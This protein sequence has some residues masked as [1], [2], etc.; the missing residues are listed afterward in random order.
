[1]HIKARN[2]N[3]AFSTALL[4]LID[5]HEE[6]NSRVGPIIAFPGPVMIEYGRPTERV[7]FSAKRNANPVF[8]LLESLWM[9][10]G[11][12]DVK[13]P[14]TIVKRMKTFS[15]DG[16]TLWGAY[17][18]RWR[19]FFGYDQIEWIISELIANPESRRCVLAMWNAMDNTQKARAAFEED[20][21]FSSD[22]YV[23]THGGKDVPCNTHIYFDCR[24]GRLNMTVCNRSND[25]VWGC[26][27]A[28][29]VHMSVL[30]E[31]MALAIGIPV[32]VY[33]QFTNDLHLYTS[34]Y[35]LDTLGPMAYDADCFDQ[36]TKGARPLPLWSGD[37]TKE[38]FDRDVADF[39]NGFDTSG[40]EILCIV[41]VEYRT[42]FFNHTVMPMVRA[43]R[44]RGN[45]D[46]AP[47]L[48]EKIA[49]PDW[50]IATRNWLL[51]NQ[52]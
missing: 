16:K 38:D 4:G 26:F 20:T 19:E 23:A 3:D 45:F 46:G 36:Y 22:L 44:A 39:F 42:E 12:N 34:H 41:G 6:R 40:I 27:G 8:H 5:H 9:L 51:R 48:A 24:G 50:A 47:R 25:L 1:M 28:N 43:W 13:F 35:P 10:A 2:V 33:R 32:G 7:L 37:E 49:A 18:F 11:R 31:Y 15:D 21:Q 52:K 30:Q 17:G 29:A 14:A